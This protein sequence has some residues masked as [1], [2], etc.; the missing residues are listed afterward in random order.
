MLCYV[1]TYEPFRYDFR[2]FLDAI[3]RA[4]EHKELVITGPA[5]KYK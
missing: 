4:F 1:V 5:K 2:Y 3:N